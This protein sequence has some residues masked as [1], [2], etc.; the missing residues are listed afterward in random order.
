MLSFTFVLLAVMACGGS[1]S[2]EDNSFLADAAASG[3]DATRGCSDPM[4]RASYR[5]HLGD[6]YW[7]DSC[8]RPGEIKET[9]GEAACVDDQCD[10]SAPCT[11][12][13]EAFCDAGD[14]YWY[15]SC[16]VRGEIKESCAGQGCDG[17]SCV[18]ACADVDCTVAPD[19]YCDGDFVRIDQGPG[20]CNLGLCEYGYSLT[21]CAHGCTSG[22][23]N[24]NPSFP[25]NAVS[26]T[27]VST[28]LIWQRELPVQEHNWQAA[29]DYCSS[30]VLDGQS[31]WRVPTISELRSV[32]TN[33]PTT[34]LG[35]AC[36]VTDA[37]TDYATCF[38]V[39]DCGLGCLP[40]SCHLPPE[41]GCLGN[42]PSRYWSS[43]AHDSVD[44]RAYSVEYVYAQVKSDF[45]TTQMLAR[46][47]R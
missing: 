9:C 28:G 44:G 14:V 23:C 18:D 41:L 19:P 6:V 37:C 25:C 2:G 27:D 5:C 34:E 47:V 33:C 20:V 31:D 15:D 22:A 45:K 17:E 16:G 26:C 7:Y 30:L 4:A 8:D 43:T 32:I 13:S 35:G 29:I 42:L 46:C 40:P 1:G 21:P 3:A 39:D 24:E 10:E 38:S 12:E 11:P 36:N